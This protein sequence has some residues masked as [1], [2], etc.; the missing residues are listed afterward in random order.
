L[1]TLV[2]FCGYEGGLPSSALAFTLDG[3]FSRATPGRTGSAGSYCGRFTASSAGAGGSI[4]HLFPDKFPTSQPVKVYKFYFRV[5]ATLGDT[6]A[7]RQVRIWECDGVSG[8]CEFILKQAI[9]TGALSIQSN[10]MRSV[11]SPVTATFSGINV[12]QWY[13]MDLKCDQTIATYKVDWQVDGVA[14]TQSTGVYGSF[15]LSWNN[16]VAII[17]GDGGPWGGTTAS[18]D[19]SFDDILCSVT[20]ADYPITTDSVVGVGSAGVTAKGTH[21]LDASPSTYFSKTGGTFLTT[22]ETTSYQEIDEVP[23]TIGTFTDFVKFAPSPATVS[24]IDARS[25]ASTTVAAL[26]RTAGDLIVV[27]AYRNTS[28]TAPALA[29]GFTDLGTASSSGG[30]AHSARVAYRVADGTATD[31]GAFTNATH[32]AFHVYRG[33]GIPTAAN[34]IMNSQNASTTMAYSALTLASLTTSWLAT[35]AGSSLTGAATAPTG[36][37]NRTTTGAGPA[38]GGNDSGAV[39]SSNWPLTNVSVSSQYYVTAVVEIKAGLTEPTN[40]WYVEYILGQPS[41]ITPEAV[42]FSA[43]HAINPA[44]GGGGT[45]VWRLSD[46]NFTN[47]TDMTVTNFAV[48]GAIDYLCM[49]TKPSGGAW[50]LAAAQALKVRWGLTNDLPTNGL[51][52]HMAYVEVAGSAVVVPTTKHYFSRSQQAAVVRAATR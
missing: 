14:Q 45:L 21:N 48:L 12:G 22:A 34:V 11:T 28:A 19:I 25:A 33:A 50:T 32:V 3:A 35:F 36:T 43:Y 51:E 49:T 26:T 1:P 39:R 44:I 17:G 40:T 7:A 29:T 30:S 23:A 2:G 37:T 13:R 47:S 24:R 8:A 15:G 18:A 52:W 5:N 4:T 38:V 6:T 46:N 9:T 31:L 10:W 41:A 16:D 42:Q 27:F 20:A